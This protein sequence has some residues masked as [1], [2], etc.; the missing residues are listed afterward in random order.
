MD[1]LPPQ[2]REVAYNGDRHPEAGAGFARGANCQHFAY[3]LLRHF[4]RS[5]PD[6]WSSELW[7]HAGSARV[8]APFA[9]LDLLLF[10]RTADPYAAHLAVFLGE[11]EAV[12]LSKRV[13]RPVVWEI[14]QFLELPE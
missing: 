2:F 11:G 14:E 13:G 1:R 12:H 5:V 7:H 8:E 10:N 6:L 9:P 3:E 4:G